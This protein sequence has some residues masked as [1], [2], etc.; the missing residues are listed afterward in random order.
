M[1]EPISHLDA[2]L[3][4]HMRGELK[5]L[6]K[7]LDTTTILVSHD[8][9]EAMSMADRIAV[10]NQGELQQLG[11]PDDVF[12]R[13][14]NLFVAGFIGDPTMNFLDCT[15]HSEG[16]KL[17]LQAETFRVNIE[18]AELSKRVRKTDGKG[19]L[20]MGIRPTNFTVSDCKTNQEYIEGEVYISEPVGESQ[21]ITIKLG[22]QTYKAVAP[23]EFRTSMGEAIWIGFD[24]KNLHLFDKETGTTIN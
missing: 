20:V 16:D 12:Y 14:A 22:T 24:M 1:D 8:Q 4:S 3:R 9:L 23:V 13:P 15:V 10:M 5:R 11:T 6:Q 18:D 2:K 17:Y 19:E 21:T 7:D